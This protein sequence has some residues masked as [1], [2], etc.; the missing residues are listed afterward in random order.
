[1]KIF[2]TI[3]FFFLL[4]GAT[5]FWLYVLKTQETKSLDEKAR[6]E[7]GGHFIRLS[8]GTVH[9]ELAGSDTGQTVIL[10]HGV[11]SGHYAWDRN[12]D[13]LV[14][15]GFRVLRY[16]LYGRG[17]SDRPQAVYDSSFFYEQLSELLY[18]LNLPP[19]YR[20]VSVSMGS[21]IAL[22]YAG[23]NMHKVSH[24]ALI[25][26]ASL[27][28]GKVSWHIRLP[29]VSEV[30]MSL[31]W[32]PRAV[33]K[34]MAEFC[35]ASTLKEYET[36]SRKQIQ[37]EGYKRAILSTWRHT[38]Q[39]NMTETMKELGKSPMKVL[40]IWGKCDRLV[41]PSNSQHYQKAMPQAT[42][43]EIDSAGHLSNYERP[44]PCNAALSK[45]LKE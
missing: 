9:Y 17:Y 32:Y 33:Q 10:I 11:G 20:L 31:Y 3:L 18:R 22:H 36:K 12:F 35:N 39:L 19:P 44:D 30:L 41:P 34:Q 16:D 21:S 2:I 15:Q 40:L 1:M 14:H 43:V 42:L 7:I 8:K 29:L 23:K 25:D 27:G 45:F 37:Y 4:V 26:P 28:K 6:R 5:A 13:Y 24:I 38:L